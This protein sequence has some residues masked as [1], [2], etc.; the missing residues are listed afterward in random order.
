VHLAGALGVPVWA[1]LP[2]SAEWR[3]LQG[4]EDS[5]WYET[6]RLYRQRALGEWQDVIQRVAR[7]LGDFAV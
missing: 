1:L 7:D 5:L 3:W 2:A 4:R 6:V